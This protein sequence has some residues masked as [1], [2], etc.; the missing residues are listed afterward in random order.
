MKIHK[1]KESRWFNKKVVIVYF[2][3]FIMIFSIG[4]F[5]ITFNTPVSS[6]RYN[7]FAFVRQGSLWITTINKV[8]IPFHYHPEQIVFYD[9]DQSII[10]RLKN[11]KAVLVTFDPNSTSVQTLE[12]VR[13]E[14]REDF[15]RLF[16]IFVGEGILKEDPLYNLPIITCE[17]ATEF[18]PVITFEENNLTGIE[19]EDN[20]IIIKGINEEFLKMKDRILYG[21]LGI[22]E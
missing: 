8:P 20:C 22:I 19:M 7:E 6:E 9:I 3:A 12:L 10:D 21:M 5:I 11:T 17:N 16:N 15:P 2:I 1:K 14:L 4:G 18:I 13:F